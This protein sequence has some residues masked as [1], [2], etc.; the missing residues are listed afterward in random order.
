[1]II[2][3]VRHRGLRQLIEHD[4]PQFLTQDLVDRV[5][6]ILTVL[7]LA[8]HLARQMNPGSR[9]KARPVLDTGSGVTEPVIM[10]PVR[11]VGLRLRLTRPTSRQRRRN[12]QL[13]AE[14]QQRLLRIGVHRNAVAQPRF[15]PFV[16]PIRRAARMRGTPGAGADC[17]ISAHNCSMRASNS[18]RGMNTVGSSTTNKCPRSWRVCGSAS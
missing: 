2:Q 8:E 3:S 1:M 14:R 10:I 9:I 15:G 5:R 7:V 13:T 18:W 11:N 6:N 16:A 17:L 12:T 4:N